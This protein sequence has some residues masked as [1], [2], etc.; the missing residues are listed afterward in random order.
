M[1]T[2]LS[3]YPL[4][5]ACLSFLNRLMIER[6]TGLPLN[7][8]FIFGEL[9]WEGADPERRSELRGERKP[10]FPDKQRR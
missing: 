4:L 5:R 1:A 7:A 10:G 8:H 2:A 6:L 9:S 3:V